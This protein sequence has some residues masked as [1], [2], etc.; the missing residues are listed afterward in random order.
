[1][2]FQQDILS[3]RKAITRGWLL[4]GA[5]FALGIAISVAGLL[6]RSR[7]PALLGLTL[8]AMGAYFCFS[9][10]LYPCIRYM[11]F[12]RDIATGL[13]RPCTGTVE[14]VS[15]TPRLSEDG[16]AVY[17]MTVIQSSDQA[18][19]LFYIDITRSVPALTLGD[20]V[21]FDAHGRYVKSFA[22]T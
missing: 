10:R 20:P 1:M 7:L 4:V 2:Y 17:E 6:S 11:R 14:S 21:T 15:T 22:H 9:I 13:S 3:E 16:V 8:G 18:P 5:V 12:L 19:S